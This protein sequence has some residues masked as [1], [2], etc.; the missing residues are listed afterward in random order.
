[1][2]SDSRR[3]RLLPLLLFIMVLVAVG[4][5]LAGVAVGATTTTLPL[6]VA[7]TESFEVR[8]ADLDGF[9]ASPPAIESPSAIVV[10][11]DTG[12]VLYERNAHKRRPMASTTKIMTAILV[13]ESGVD[14]S[15]PVTVSA[16]AANTWEVSAWVREGDVLTV[17]QLLYALM[18]RSANGSAVA[19]A[20]NDAGS[21]SAFVAKMNKQAQELGMEDTNFVTTNGL[22]AEG[23][24]ST[25]ADL[26][27]LARYAMKNEKF[28]EMVDSETYTLEVQESS[29]T[30]GRREPLEITNTNKLLLQ[31]DWVNGIKT[32]LTPK[33]EQCLVA[34][35][36]KD[37]RSVISVV[38]GQPDSPQCFQESKALMEYGFTQFRPLKLVEKGMT[39][40]EAEVPYQMDG[41]VELV[42]DGALETELYAEDVVR[43]TITVDRAL[44]LPVAAGETYGHV[45]VT[46]GGKEVGRCD[47]VASKSFPAPTLGSK[48]AYFFRR[49][50]AAVGIG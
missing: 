45:V 33:A 48:L 49:L 3:G 44:E 12:K 28:R 2:R 9:D 20:E 16:K 24:Y 18:L 23:H 34:S 31:Y 22:D 35:G 25:A 19:L 11:L 43:T 8:A 27:T 42:T 6:S 15:T 40:A 13:L 10:S 38:L 1:M 30:K 47:L 7:Q 4:S 21:V 39:V 14:L 36:T 17:E 29:S 46:A 32:G 50:G 5:V 37:G 41:K 26:A